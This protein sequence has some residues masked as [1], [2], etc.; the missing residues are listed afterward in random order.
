LLDC[1]LPPTQVL[2]DIGYVIHFV[3]GVLDYH[4][5]DLLYTG[6]RTYLLPFGEPV[7]SFG[8]HYGS[9]PGAELG[10]PGWLPRC[11]LVTDLDSAATGHSFR[12]RM[13]RLARSIYCTIARPKKLLLNLLPLERMGASFGCCCWVLMVFCG[14]CAFSTDHFRARVH[15][16]AVGAS[17]GSLSIHVIPYFALWLSFCTC[18]SFSHGLWGCCTLGWKRRDLFMLC[19]ASWDVVI[20]RLRVPLCG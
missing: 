15:L 18:F 13:T 2:P 11:A 17:G 8:C 14:V 12:E 4:R 20:P 9:C 1:L 19:G 6:D 16:L 3:P 10:I 7:C 5:L